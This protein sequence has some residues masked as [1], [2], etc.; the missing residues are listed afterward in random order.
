[1]LRTLVTRAERGDALVRLIA[2]DG[3]TR[4]GEVPAEHVRALLDV[5]EPG[6]ADEVA[7]AHSEGRA[8]PDDIVSQPINEG[9]P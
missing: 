8:P 4:P 5:D 9:G 7:T 1:M 3:S 2:E 6:R